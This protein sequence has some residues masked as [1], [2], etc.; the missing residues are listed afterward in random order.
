M[1]PLT[2]VSAHKRCDTIYLIIK[3]S[4]NSIGRTLIPEK[5]SLADTQTVKTLLAGHTFPENSLKRTLKR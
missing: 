3:Y 2:R 1:F 5:P 4:E